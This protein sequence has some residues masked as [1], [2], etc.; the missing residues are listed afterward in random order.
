MNNQTQSGSFK[1]PE[2]WPWGAALV[3]VALILLAGMVA[4]VFT[5]IP[6]FLSGDVRG[7]ARC[8][9]LMTLATAFVLRGV[10]PV[11]KPFL[12]RNP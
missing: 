4:A 6:L 7:A 2:F 11:A 1:A 5:A 12:L 8:V 3:V 9:A 10:W